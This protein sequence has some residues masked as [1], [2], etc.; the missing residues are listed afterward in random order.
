MGKIL[1][2]FG[3]EEAF[4]HFVGPSQQFK[5]F[6]PYTIGTPE[7]LKRELSYVAQKG[8]AISDQEAV[9][10]CRCIAVPVRNP[11]RKFVAAL[12]ISNTPEKFGEAAI[13]RL[14]SKLFAAADAIG[15]ETAD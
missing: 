6:T 15:R 12:S 9:L 14:L 1:L 7:D 8:Y 13:P 3:G 4:R 5:R 2:A 11:R 10:G